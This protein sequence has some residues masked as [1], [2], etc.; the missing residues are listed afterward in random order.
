M[1][2]QVRKIARYKMNIQQSIEY[3]SYKNKQWKSESHL[4]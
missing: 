2:L 1:I 4:Q 3:P